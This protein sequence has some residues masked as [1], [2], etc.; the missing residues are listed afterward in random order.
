MLLRCWAKRS[1]TPTCRLVAAFERGVCL[2]NPAPGG[3]NLTTKL[4]EQPYAYKPRTWALSGLH[5]ISDATLEMHFGLY[6]GYVKNTNLLRERIA[7]I[8][9]AGK[10]AGTDPSF[11]ELVR[12]MGFELDGMRLHELY[13]DNL[14]SRPQPLG[15]NRLADALDTNF[16]GFESWRD[17]FCAIGGMRGNGWAIAYY[18]TLSQRIDNYWIDD[19][20]SGHIAG[21]VPIVVMDV[22]EHAF[23]KDYK[24]ADK[25][26]YI[27]AFLA[28]VDW[29]ACADRMP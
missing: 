14:T 15:R 13:F 7:G 10:A 12:R 5:G 25:S 20:Q 18:D 2:G 11:A 8:R 1:H 4:V 23:I 29:A 6:Q 19:H 21:A 24:P 27:E 26:K 28:N 16:G 3:L 22:W 17:E 9:E